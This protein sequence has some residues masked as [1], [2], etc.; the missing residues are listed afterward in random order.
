LDK[1]LKL[2]G[3]NY[4]ENKLANSFGYDS[5]SIQ[6][7]VSAQDVQ[8]VLPAAVSIAPFDRGEKGLSKSGEDYL[9]VDYAKMVPLLIEAIKE[10]KE[11]VDSLKGARDEQ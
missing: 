6:V 5:T 4:I 11:E 2:N 9:T 1:V 7:G 3:F 8:K 10:L